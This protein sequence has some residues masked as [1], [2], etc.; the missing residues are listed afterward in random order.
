MDR[1]DPGTPLTTEQFEWIWE[2]C[3]DRK[4]NFPS[5]PDIMTLGIV[6][7]NIGDRFSKV[8]CTVCE[9]SG[10]KMDIPKRE[11]GVPNCPDGHPLMETG[12]R[13]R[14]GWVEITD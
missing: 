12:E 1:P 7:M 8:F 6:M 4:R 3:R 9:W 11:D 10:I 13:L 2:A 14:I 5:E